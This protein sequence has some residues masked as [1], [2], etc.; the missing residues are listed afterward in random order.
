[1]TVEVIDNGNGTLSTNVSY[2]DEVFN[3]IYERV[4]VKVGAVWNDKDN[5]F[6]YRPESIVVRLYADG[7]EIDHAIVKES[8]GWKCVFPGLDKYMDGKKVNYTI[9]ED[10]F[11]GYIPTIH[12]NAENDYVII[13]D[14]APIGGGDPNDFVVTQAVSNVHIMN[15]RTG[16]YDHVAICLALSF[17]S[18]C[19]MIVAT[20][21][22]NN[23]KNK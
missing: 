14:L 5:E 9:S 1:M 11:F 19:T 2:S 21:R 4:D 8:D 15:P 17:A 12:K 16:A 23:S 10:K 13:H 3:N 22:Y 6:R 20:K 18:I 7:V